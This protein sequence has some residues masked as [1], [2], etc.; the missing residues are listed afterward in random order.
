MRAAVV[1]AFG[2]PDVIA[3]EEVADPVPGPGELEIAV[4]FVNVLWVETMIR[5]G[6]A[7][8]HFDHEP[9][10]VPGN[11]VA[12]HV[13]AVGEGVDAAWVGRAVVAH[14]GGRGGTFSAHGTPS[15]ASRRSIEARRSGGTSP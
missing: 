8:G 3:I 2:D 13:R 12:G 4:T 7:R 1:T 15:G 9:P 6:V 5:R 10:Y 14:T 11:G